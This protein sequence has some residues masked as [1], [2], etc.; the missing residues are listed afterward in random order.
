MYLCT[1]LHLKK[2]LKNLYGLCFG[3]MTTKSFVIAEVIGHH[4]VTMVAWVQSQVRSCGICGGQS[5]IGMG[6]LQ[7]LSF[8]LPVLTQPTAAHSLI[9]Q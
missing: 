9:I 4:L 1:F 3:L 8:R 7:V 6:F 2:I 5:G